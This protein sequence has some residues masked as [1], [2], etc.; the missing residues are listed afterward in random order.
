MCA[1][2]GASV[3]FKLQVWYTQ[4]LLMSNH[5]MKYPPMNALIPWAMSQLALMQMEMNS[6]VSCK[7]RRKTN[8]ISN[9]RVRETGSTQDAARAPLVNGLP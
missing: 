1:R 3:N 8:K 9:S 4:T 5:V 2:I 6:S 7:C